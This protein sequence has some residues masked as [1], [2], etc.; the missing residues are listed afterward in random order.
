MKLKLFAILTGVDVA[1]NWDRT[2]RLN[3]SLPCP[4]GG[5]SDHGWFVPCGDPK[6]NKMHHIH[7]YLRQKSCCFRMNSTDFC[8]FENPIINIKR[9]CIF[10][11]RINNPTRVFSRSEDGF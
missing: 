2:Q 4:S 8:G 10:A 5:H 7:Q 6:N 9:L 1:Q 11:E 3:R